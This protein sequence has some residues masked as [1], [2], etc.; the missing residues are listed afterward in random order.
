MSDGSSYWKNIGISDQTHVWICPVSYRLLVS[1]Y[2]SCW[3]SPV[4][5]MSKTQDLRKFQPSTRRRFHGSTVSGPKNRL[6]VQLPGLSL[7]ACILISF[8]SA[9]AQNVHC[10]FFRECDEFKSSQTKQEAER[11]W[12]IKQKNLTLVWTSWN[13]YCWD[14]L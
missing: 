4:K 10:C 1:V 11:L 2:N 12:K 13:W 3:I 7:E 9:S 5:K 8:Q 6:Q 14:V